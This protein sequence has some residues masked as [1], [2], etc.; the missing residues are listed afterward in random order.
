MTLDPAVVLQLPDDPNSGL[1]GAFRVDRITHDESDSADVRTS[2][3]A[4]MVEDGLTD[5]ELRRIYEDDEVER[6]LMLFS[7]VSFCWHLMPP[8]G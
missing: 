4:S 2:G 7:S 6:F 5:N 8:K 1:P 3:T